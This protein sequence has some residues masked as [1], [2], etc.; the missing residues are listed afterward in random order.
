M[1]CRPLLVMASQVH[2][3]NRH[4][5]DLI[6]HGDRDTRLLTGLRARLS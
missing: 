4:G 2:L 6:I 1:A 5:P 3:G